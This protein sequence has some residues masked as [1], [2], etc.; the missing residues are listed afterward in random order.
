MEAGLPDVMFA[1][2]LMKLDSGGFAVANFAL[3]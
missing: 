2:D 3:E 1:I